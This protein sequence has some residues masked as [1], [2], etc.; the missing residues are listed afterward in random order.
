MPDTALILEVFF[1]I[2]KVA[3]VTMILFGMPLPLTWLERKVAGHIHARLGPW[4]VG[5]HGVLQP[6]ADMIKLLLKEDICPSMSDRLL[7]K[8]APIIS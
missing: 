8:I 4:R 6:F 2:V 5:P 7:F 1:I 3:V